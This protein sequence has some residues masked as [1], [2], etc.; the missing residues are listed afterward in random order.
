M[1]NK[2]ES[3]F[4]TITSATCDCCDSPIKVVF[5]QI[6]DDHTILKGYV[7]GGRNIINAIICDKCIKE[8]LSFINF[9]QTVNSVGFC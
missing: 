7:D 8:K 9:K 6:K 5:G 1:I 4:E 3:T 2:T